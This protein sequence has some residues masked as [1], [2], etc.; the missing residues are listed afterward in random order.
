MLT[1]APLIIGMTI[2]ASLTL[3][4]CSATSAPDAA[5]TP[6]V[7]ATPDTLGAG[8]YDRS[9]PPA[10][11]GTIAPTDGSWD[12]AHPPAGYT[13]ALLTYGDEAETRTLV[14]AVKKWAADE[15]IDLQS[16][17]ADSGDTLIPAITDAID[18][19]PDLIISVGHQMVDALAALSPSYLHQQFLVVGAE[20]AE[21]TANVTAADWTGAGYRGEGLGTPTDHDPASFTDERAARAVRA[22]VASV[23]N[24]L[25]GIVVWV[26]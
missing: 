12:D 4:G 19:K 15:D 24:N 16:V 9:N 7:S 11:E 23:V 3:A 17:V 1:R 21:P 13:V 20:I 6:S 5:P 22:G 14:A 25:T 18:L 8:F 26:S 10:P 2:A